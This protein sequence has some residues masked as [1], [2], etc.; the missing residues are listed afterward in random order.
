MTRS[1]MATAVLL[2]WVTAAFAGERLP[3]GIVLPDV[4]PPKVGYSTEPMAVPYLEKPPE[5]ISIDRGRQLF[6][7]DF[8]IASTTLKRTYHGPTYHAASPVLRPVTVWERSNDGDF[9]A[10]YSDGVWFD[11]TRRRFMMWY[12]AA[13]LRTCLAVS[14]DGLRWMRPIFDIEAGTNVVLTSEKKSS[15]RDSNTVWL[16]LNAA[17]PQER[18]KL[19]ETRYARSP[20]RMALRTSADG[21]HWST[22]KAVSARSWDR[23]TAFYNPFRNVWVASVRGHDHEKGA[24]PHRLRNYFEGRTAAEA[25]SW[26]QDTDEVSKRKGL[27]G[28]LTSWLGADRLDPPHPNPQVS[29]EKPQLYNLDVFPYESVLVG[30]FTIWRRPTNEVCAQLTRISHHPT[31]APDRD[32]DGRLSL[33]DE[34]KGSLTGRNSEA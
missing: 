3:N 18:F 13:E 5:V 12:R 15:Q 28:D 7:D 2:A 31:A 21:I 22:E 8:L 6:V 27:A 23:S 9:A 1:E 4:W 30:L 29:T 26:R 14:D 32:R 24:P 11:P 33:R 34:V 10:P 25:V 20:Y 16:D 19:F 17:D